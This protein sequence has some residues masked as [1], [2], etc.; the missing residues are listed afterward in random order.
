MLQIIE[1]LS[2]KLALFLSSKVVLPGYSLK[3]SSKV[4]HYKLGLTERI[5]IEFFQKSYS[6]SD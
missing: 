3:K 4:S 6:F 2:R 5:E 1:Q